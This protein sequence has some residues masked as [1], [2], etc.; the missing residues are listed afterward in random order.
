MEHCGLWALRPDA[1]ITP[2]PLCSPFSPL[3]HMCL[4]P[5][6]GRPL[7]LC[8]THCAVTH[9]GRELPIGNHRLPRGAG[10]R[11]CQPCRDAT[12]MDKG[13]KRKMCTRCR[14]SFNG[15]LVNCRECRALVNSTMRR[16]YRTARVTQKAKDA[17]SLELYLH[18]QRQLREE[19]GQ[20]L[21][22]QQQLRREQEQFVNLLEQLLHQP[23]QHLQVRLFALMLHDVY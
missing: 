3:S 15:D 16:Y 19:R 10:I 8:P 20:L 11:V 2:A 22:Q 12:P 4:P 14:L 1:F 13:T 6:M 5:N 23:P 17:A 9:C 21:Q 18:Q 7:L